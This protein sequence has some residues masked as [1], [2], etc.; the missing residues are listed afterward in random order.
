MRFLHSLKKMSAD[1]FE[2][3][4][5]LQPAFIINSLCAMKALF[6]M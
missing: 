2:A 5:Y 4:E 6:I 3:T 1:V